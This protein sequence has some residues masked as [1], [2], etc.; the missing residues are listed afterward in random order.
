M[1][2]RH[3]QSQYNLIFHQCRN[4]HRAPG[5]HAIHVIVGGQDFRFAGCQFQPRFEPQRQVDIAE[6][7]LALQTHRAIHRKFEPRFTTIVDFA[8]QDEFDGRTGTAGLR[9]PGHRIQA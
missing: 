3:G 2:G 9:E 7:T 6:A 5:Q 4:A 1:L 8:G